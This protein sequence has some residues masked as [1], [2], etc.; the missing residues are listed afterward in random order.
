MRFIDHIPTDIIFDVTD[1]D[2]FRAVA[3]RMVRSIRDSDIAMELIAS[4]E[5]SAATDELLE[6]LIQ[7]DT[8]GLLAPEMMEKLKRKE[9]IPEAI[10]G[11]RTAIRE[12]RMKLVQ[13]MRE[14]L[15][16]KP[17]PDEHFLGGT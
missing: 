17:L 14:D 3:M 12:S 7:T 5:V 1:E 15:G 4:L 6:I 10:A 2:D 11:Y 16:V 13:V 9:G 8:A